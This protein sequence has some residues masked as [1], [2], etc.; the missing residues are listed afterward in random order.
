MY[1]GGVRLFKQYVYPI[2]AATPLQTDT[3]VTRSPSPRISHLAIGRNKALMY[4]AGTTTLII[5]DRAGCEER[6]GWVAKSE[7]VAGRIPCCPQPKHTDCTQGNREALLRRSRDTCRVSCT[8]REACDVSKIKLSSRF[9]LELGYLASRFGNLG[10]WSVFVPVSA[11]KRGADRLYLDISLQDD[12]TSGLLI[13]SQRLESR[14][15]S[16]HRSVNMEQISPKAKRKET[17]L[18]PFMKLS[19][20]HESAIVFTPFYRDMILRDS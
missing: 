1:Q 13:D 3:E 8:P 18:S 6:V 19:R 20:L 5:L 12:G 9:I 10:T 7:A 16:S 15:K 17:S 14:N 4:K 2:A 11:R